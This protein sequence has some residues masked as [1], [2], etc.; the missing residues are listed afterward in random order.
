MGHGY[1]WAAD[2]LGNLCLTWENTN[3]CLS[4]EKTAWW[5]PQSYS[6]VPGLGMW[7]WELILRKPFSSY[8]PQDCP[9]CSCQN[10]SFCTQ[11]QMANLKQCATL[12]WWHATITTVA[13]GSHRSLISEGNYT[14]MLVPMENRGGVY[15]QGSGKQWQQLRLLCSC[16]V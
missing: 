6:Y 12:I 16:K 14:H 15:I 11:Q 4:F 10:G 9:I 7:W 8:G 1:W 5:D 2:Q 3:R 13:M